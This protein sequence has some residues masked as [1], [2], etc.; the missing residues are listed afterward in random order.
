MKNEPVIVITAIVTVVEAVI[1]ASVG[2]GLDWSPEQIGSVMAI[3]IAIGGLA[4][5]FFVR[6]KV[7][8]VK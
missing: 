1:A 4:Q 3:V 5:A 6:Q 8:P 7:S 2:F